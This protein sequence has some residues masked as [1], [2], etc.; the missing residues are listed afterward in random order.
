MKK[1]LILLAFLVIISAAHAARP[2]MVVLSNS[3]DKPL[4]GELF[5]FLENRGIN[6]THTT[7]SN[8]DNHKEAKFIL[9]LG[10]PDA[11]EGVGEIVQ[12][13][14]S[15]NERNHLRERKGN[16]NLYIKTNHWATSQVIMVVAGHN[17][18]DTVDAGTANK[19]TISTQTGAEEAEAEENETERVATIKLERLEHKWKTTSGEITWIEYTMSNFGNTTIEP[20]IDLRIF[21]E[22]GDTLVQAYLDSDIDP[23]N[24]SIEFGQ[25][26][27]FYNNITVDADLD[28]KGYY[29]VILELRHGTASDI[30]ASSSKRIHLR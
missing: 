12:N 8:F 9:I 26:F 19:A 1:I 17:R 18:Y 16:R 24:E 27:N 15:E 29:K 23:W 25:N 6:I 2:D 7:V 3:I 4:A 21:K 13:I 22:S 30:I 11:P 28:E 5:D 10:G 14:L 20:V